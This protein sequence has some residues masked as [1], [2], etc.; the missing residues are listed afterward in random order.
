MMQRLPQQ[1]RWL[2]KRIQVDDGSAFISKALDC[3]AC[4]QH[5][6][7]TFFRPGKPANNPCLDSFNGIFRKYCLNDLQPH[8][9]LQNLTP[10][11][12]LSTDAVVGRRAITPTAVEPLSE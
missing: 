10:N 8:S 5:V 4:D 6:T 9:S 12:L 1:V 2:P 3:W 11:A 7:L